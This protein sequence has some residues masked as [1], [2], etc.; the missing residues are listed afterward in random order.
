MKKI[1]RKQRDR[2]VV[3]GIKFHRRAVKKNRKEKKLKKTHQIYRRSYTEDDRWL[4][5]KSEEGY[6]FSIDHNNRVVVVL[7]EKMN[8]S[9]QYEITAVYISAIRKL[10]DHS[11]TIYKLMSVNFDGLREI[12]TSAALVLTA[13]LSKWNDR[14]K[15]PLRPVTDGWDADIFIRLYELGF[16]NLFRNHD[17]TDDPSSDETE[18]IRFVKYIKGRSGDGEKTRHL[19]DEIFRLVDDV[20]SKWTF[21]YSGLTEAITNVSHHAYPDSYAGR[22]S[23]KNWY[24]SGS[25]QKS[26]NE[27]KIVFYDQGIGIPESL[28]VSAIWERIL[29][30]L[31]RF[32]V[33]DRKKDKTLLKAAVELDRTSTADTDRG[34]GLQDL[35]EFIRQ[36]DNGY[37]SILSKRGLYKYTTKNGKEHVKS[38]SFRNPIYG[39]LIIWNVTLDH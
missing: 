4:K 38:E 16:F 35:L 29:N 20:V 9:D 39:T 12:S 6:Q 27:L 1:N 19:K 31:S 10:T 36:R 22:D 24:L 8:F 37:L 18:D 13:E 34:K 21:L 15:Q 25:Y 3:A 14:E 33:A 32:P 26:T 23:D 7:P 17:I 28:P 5:T 11:N 30:A 2:D